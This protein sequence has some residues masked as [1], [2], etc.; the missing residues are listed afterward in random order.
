MSLVK[1]SSTV[2]AVE[3]ILSEESGNSAAIASRVAVTLFDGL[4]LL[5]EGIQDQQSNS[6]IQY[7]LILL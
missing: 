4:E 3:A 5:L 6:F 1:T 2:A 7:L